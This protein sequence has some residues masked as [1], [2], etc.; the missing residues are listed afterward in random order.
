ML[1]TKQQIFQTLTKHGD[2]L[3]AY[4][5]E[6]IGLFGSY[7]R[8]EAGANS[9]IDLLVNITK[10]KKTFSNFMSLSYYLE[11]LLGRKVDVITSQSLSPH[12][13]PHILNTVEYVPLA[14]WI[15]KAHS[16]RM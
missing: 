3:K 16:R 8:E 10:S 1:I 4:G 7:V 12:I 13:G 9:D 14:G 5:V 15:F 6:Q 11:E 2:E